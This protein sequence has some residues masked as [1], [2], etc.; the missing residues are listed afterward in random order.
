MTTGI[1][2]PVPILRFCDNRGNPLVGGSLLCQVGGVNTPVYADSGLTTPLPNPVPLNSRGEVST[3][4]GASSEM[5]LTPNTVYSMTLSDASG[6]Q[7]WVA[8][9]VTGSVLTALQIAAL[10]ST[11]TTA[12]VLASYAQ[13][14]A[15]LAAGVTPTNYAYEPYTILRYGGDPTG[16]NDSTIALQTA[17]NA[18]AQA[19][20]SEVS[21]GV[22]G[23]ILK[24]GSSWSVNTNEVG[25]DFQGAQLNASTFS[26][27]NWLAPTQS[28]SDINMRAIANQTH[29]IMNATFVGPGASVTGVTCLYLNDTTST[30]PL[31]A[32][33]K[34][35]NVA[36]VDWGQD[37]VFAAGAFAESFDSCVFAVSSGGGGSTAT[38]AS[39]TIQSAANSGERI[40]FTDCAWY[41]K[42]SG[43]AGAG[44]GYINQLSGTSDIYLVGC[45]LDTGTRLV[46]CSGGGK[47]FLSN[48]HLEVS[49]D[50]DY[51][52]HVTENNSEV[53][54]ADS[55]IIFN[56]AR[57]TYNL[58]YSDSSVIWGGLYIHDC[59]FSAQN[60][61]SVGALIGGTGNARAQNIHG[62][63]TAAGQPHI[64]SAAQNAIGDN[65]FQNN[66]FTRDGWT[67]SGGAPPTIV[68]SNPYSGTYSVEFNPAASQT[69]VLTSRTIPCAPGQQGCVRA[70]AK[71]PTF[72][73]GASFTAYCSYVD[74]GGN[75]LPTYV[76]GAPTTSF[77][78]MDITAA[79]N[80]YAEYTSASNGGLG[81]APPGTVGFNVLFE[82]ATGS[83]GGATGYLGEVDVT[84]G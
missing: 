73:T 77:Q 84:I 32:G 69:S 79:I 6:N 28:L 72:S 75:S 7:I 62:I 30:P 5:F 39:I 70:F 34:F 54:V 56:N 67:A 11:V 59:T 26:A 52:I 47:V 12:P 78:F 13:T 19:G 18:A 20:N 51:L 36:F 40:V 15:E 1:E 74:Y 17:C 43:A 33:L 64:Y 37:V 9:Y 46:N 8:T 10:T 57:N 76:G 2:A 45:S 58:G 42:E 44:L 23:A 55:D 4:A 38:T 24:I 65:I 71:L 3:A 21:V 22:A 68:A 49:N 50:L 25:I 31:I 29:P 82:L 66:S 41:N 80:A 16:T 48:C 27:G 61:Y 53:H 83:A 81:L 63:G 14:P 60:G 35:K